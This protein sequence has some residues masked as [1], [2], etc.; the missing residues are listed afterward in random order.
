MVKTD[1]CIIGCKCPLVLHHQSLVREIGHVE[2]PCPE[3]PL[4]A[5]RHLL[6]FQNALECTISTY[7]Y[8][9][10]SSCILCFNSSILSMVSL[11]TICIAGVSTTSLSPFSPLLRLEKKKSLGKT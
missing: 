1:Y 10:C 2:L 7:L 9:C 11:R 6:Y 3:S 5:T 4:E 8:L